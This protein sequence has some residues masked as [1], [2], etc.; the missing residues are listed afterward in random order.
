MATPP[1]REARTLKDAFAMRKVRNESFEYMTGNPRRIG[2]LEQIIWWHFRRPLTGVYLLMETPG[3]VDRRGNITDPVTNGYGIITVDGFL[4]GAIR[5]ED[6]G[7]GWGEALF[8]E[9][10]DVV[11]DRNDDP[12]LDVHM[13]N[14]KAISLYKK[15]GFIPCGAGE[16][17][18]EMVY[19]R[20]KGSPRKVLTN[21][22]NSR[23]RT[24]QV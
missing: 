24:S 2:W 6:R 1:I 9:M 13:D 17:K 21:A 3:A 18:M 11:V 23:T 12:R 14:E 5:A 22:A 7:K 4:T 15:L 10:M 20:R 8:V 19:D 16:K